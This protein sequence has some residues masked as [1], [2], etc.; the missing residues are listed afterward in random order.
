MDHSKTGPDFKW[1]TIRKPDVKYV[2]FSNVSG[3]RMSGFRIPTV[4]ELPGIQIV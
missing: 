4:L 3:F 2:R 1:S